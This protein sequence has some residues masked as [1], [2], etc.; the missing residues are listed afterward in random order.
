MNADNGACTVCVHADE[1]I[2][3]HAPK[4]GL[5]LGPHPGFCG[6]RTVW[7]IGVTHTETGIEA[8]TQSDLPRLLKKRPSDTHKADCG[9]VLVLA[10]SPGKAGAAAMCALGALKAGSG[11]VTI[12]TDEALIPVLQTSLPNAMCEPLEN[13]VA[14]PPV[15]DVLAAGCSFGTGADRRNA[16]IALLNRSRKAVLDA[17]ALT[18]LAADPF[19]IP[20]PAVLTPHVGEAARLLGTDTKTV[21]DDLPG[22]AKSISERYQSTVLLKSAVSVIADGERLALNV[23]GSPSLSKGGSGDAL[24]GILASTYFECDDPFEAARVAALR[25]GMAGVEGEKR[26]GVRG[27]LTSEM[28]NCLL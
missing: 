1:T 23:V 13:A 12:A 22:A 4:T 6:R 16:L 17:D 26:H 11:L 8:Y 25:L 21:L 27:L 3:F 7:D 24:C 9:R 28:L 18:M 14:A 5:Y 10:G 2:T 15:F 20:C 19:P